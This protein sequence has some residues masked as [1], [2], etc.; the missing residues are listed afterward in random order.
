MEVDR[1]VVE[2]LGQR[3]T[4]EGTRSGFD[5][6]DVEWIGPYRPRDEIEA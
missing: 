3:V 5:R 1:P 4:V 2:L 6:L